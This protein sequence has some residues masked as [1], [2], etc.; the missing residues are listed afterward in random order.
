M[1]SSSHSAKRPFSPPQRTSLASGD[2]NDESASEA[3]RG[4]TGATGATADDPTDEVETVDMERWK[5]LYEKPFHKELKVRTRGRF[6]LEMEQ[7]AQEL[8]T[9]EPQLPM[10]SIQNALLFK[11]VT[12]RKQLLGSL[13]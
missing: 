12:S 3:K 5:A 9:E 10:E 6:H 4:A 11:R 2:G 7:K 1:L 8:M 13:L